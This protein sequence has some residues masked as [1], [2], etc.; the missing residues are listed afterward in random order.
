MWLGGDSWQ[1]AKR[2]LFESMEMFHIVIV[3]IVT[4]LYIFVQNS[5]KSTLKIAE[6][7]VCK[8]CPN[9]TDSQKRKVRNR[10]R[11]VIPSVLNKREKR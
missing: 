2:D 9:K 11:S 3:M 4:Q 5:L 10:I 8:L 6:F 1:R 7:S